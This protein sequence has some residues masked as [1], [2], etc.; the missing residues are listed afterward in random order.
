MANALAAASAAYGSLAPSVASPKRAEALVFVDVTRRLETIYSDPTSS[1]A[2]KVGVLHDNRRL[3][4]AAATALADRDNDL[5]ESLRG[6]LLNLAAFV[7]RHTSAILRGNGSVQALC[8]INRRVIA[9]L[10]AG[11]R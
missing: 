5:P 9:G 1:A 10:S 8:E 7:D 3:W 11:A 6:S 4:L 2:S